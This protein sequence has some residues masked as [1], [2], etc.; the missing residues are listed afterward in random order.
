MAR[1]TAVKDEDI[2]P[3]LL[4]LR[5]KRKWQITLRRYVL[6]KSPCPAYAP[7]FGLDI[8]NMRKWFEFQFLDGI[9]WGDFGE[10]WQ[11]EHIVPVSYFDFDQEEDLKLCWNFLNLRP[12]SIEKGK[13]LDLLMSK[14]YFQSLFDQTSNETCRKM[15]DKIGELEKSTVLNNSLIKDFIQTNADYLASI[16]SFAAYEFE[17]LNAGRS[18]EEI[19]KEISLVTNIGKSI[20]GQFPSDPS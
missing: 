20:P 1:R 8:E 14:S 4:K 15:L 9:G 12:G 16:R 7:Y 3:S 5:E 10:K 6:E 11:F 17:L 18:V 13:E 2:T 19:Q